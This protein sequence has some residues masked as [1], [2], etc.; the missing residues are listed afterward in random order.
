MNSINKNLK[1]AFSKGVFEHEDDIIMY[2]LI[3]NDIEMN[4]IQLL[5]QCC[6]TITKIV[7]Y[8]EKKYNKSISYNDWVATDEIKV[9]LKAKQEDLLYSINNYSDTNNNIW[10]DHTFDVDNIDSPFTVTSVV[11]TPMLRKDTPNFL[12]DLEFL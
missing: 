5:N 6:T 7:R 4:K 2:I 10:C 11:F 12:M 8:N 9:F 1:S 3:N